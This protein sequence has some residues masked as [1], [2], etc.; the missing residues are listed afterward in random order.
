MSGGDAVSLSQPAAELHRLLNGFQISQAI[1]V[2]AVLGVADQLVSGPRS[3]DEIAAAV[4]AH[5]ASLYR[6][7]RALAAAGV[8]REEAQRRFSL[9]PMGECLRSGAPQP[10]RPFATFIGQPCQWQAWGELLYSVRTGENAFQSVHGMSSWEYRARHPDQNAI[11]NAAMTGNSQRINQ[12]IVAAYDF[13][14]FERIGDVGGGQGALLAA[15][16]VANPA[17]RGVLFDLPH[18]VDSA[19]PLLAAAAV[20]DRCQIVGGN[21]FE[22]V[23]PGCAAY[24]LK[25]ILHDWGDPECVRLLRVCRRAMDPGTVLLAIDRFVGLP[26]ADAAVKF[27]DLHMLVGP[28]G[29]ERTC[30]EFSALF[31]AAGLRLAQ[32]VITA[33]PV[34]M[35]IAEP[36]AEMDTEAG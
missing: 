24:L 25:Y 7:L 16:L 5:P 2:A 17:V 13:A 18:V 36:A 3:S 31:A 28:G 6:L 20:A 27:S 33:A 32:V 1:Y 35:M 21:M 10:V 34:V 22:T 14:R 15:I 26:N 9:T 8:F 30:E 23:P 4:G 11:F 29:Q 12:A 19:G